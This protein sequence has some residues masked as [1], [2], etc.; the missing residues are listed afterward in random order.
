MRLFITLLLISLNA[1]AVLPVVDLSTAPPKAA[2]TNQSLIFDAPGP[3]PG[4]G[5]QLPYSN[6][7]A[8][9]RVGSG[10]NFTDVAYTDLI[11]APLLNSVHPHCFI[12]NIKGSI[13]TSTLADLKT[14]ATSN[15]GGIENRSSYW[16]PCLIDTRTNSI[17][18]FK[19][20]PIIYYNGPFAEKWFDDGMELLVDKADNK[21]SNDWYLA[22]KKIIWECGGV[23]SPLIPLICGEGELLRLKL[24]FP[25]C[26]DG[27]LSSPDHYSHLAYAG[28]YANGDKLT[29]KDTLPNQCP[30]THPIRLPDLSFIFGFRMND[31]AMI[32]YVRLSSDHIGDPAGISAHADAFEAH[33]PAFKVH[34]LNNCLKAKMDCGGKNIG[35]VNG[36][37]KVLGEV[38]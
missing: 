11:I 28:Y 29:A 37:Y 31:P 4:P 30:R 15:D 33:G 16:F 24:L 14:A 20:R 10:V 9:I 25:S 26:S 17:V 27:R 36:V 32:N 2:T 5:Y 8:K 22:Q 7:Q 21:N 1:S 6:G 23:G 35:Q 3:N 13:S 34:I 19:V 18:P 38:N 12:G